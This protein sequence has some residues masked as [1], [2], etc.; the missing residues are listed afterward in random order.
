MAK[1]I[2]NTIAGV[3]LFKIRAFSALSF[4][5][6][7]SLPVGAQTPGAI[8]RTGFGVRYQ[9]PAGWEWTEFN[10]VRVSL[11]HVATLTGEKGKEVSLN[12]FAFGAR[13]VPDESFDNSWDRLDRDRRRTFASGAAARWRAGPRWGNAHYVFAGEI[14]PGAGTVVSVSLLGYSSR[15]FDLSIVESAFV[16]VA[17]SLRKVDESKTIYHPTGQFAVDLLDTK[18]WY[19]NATPVHVVFRCWAN[20]RSG[21]TSIFLYPAGQFADL[22]SVLADITNYFAKADNLTIGAVQRREIPGGELL[23]TEQAGTQRPI[24]GAVR[25]DGKYFFISTSLDNTSGTCTRQALTQD[26]L[27]VARTVRSWDGN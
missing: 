9:I 23:W 4:V 15:P 10:G 6:A 2:T 22:H 21:N 17:E 8:I 14:N 3:T 20:G 27:S 25:R 19:V 24:L 7:L 5:I 12:S 16:A 13:T 26:V 11:R 1:T 18:A